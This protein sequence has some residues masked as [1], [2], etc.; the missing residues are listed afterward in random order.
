MT[1]YRNR[2]SGVALIVGLIIL[3]LLTIIMI[4]ALKVT[5]LEE[6]MSGNSQN[7]NV[8]FQAAESALREAEAL[9]YQHVD[10]NPQVDWNGDGGQ[11]ANPFR[12]FK[13]T[14]GYFQNATD[15]IC[16][17]GL[18]GTTDP[19]QSEVFKAVTP[20]TTAAAFHAAVGSRTAA[21]GITGLAVDAD[22]NSIEPEYIIEY[23]TDEADTTRPNQR[24]VWFRITARA[25]GPGNSVEQLQSIYKIHAKHFS[26]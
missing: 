24:Y 17:E 10:L 12:P 2:Q 5:A 16:W 7:Q 26:H 11:E 8:A 15:P 4:T 25:W 6:R 18:C 3:L 22:G 20:S 19:L 14:N 1:G 21:T 9:I 23:V 13:M